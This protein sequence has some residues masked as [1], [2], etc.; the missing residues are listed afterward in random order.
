[1]LTCSKKECNENAT[2]IVKLLLFTDV[3]AEP[4][5]VFATICAC[6]EEHQLPDGEIHKFFRD[7]WETLATGFEQRGFPRPNIDKTQF[8]WVPL[9]DYEEFKRMCENADPK[10]RVV[11]WKN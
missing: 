8:A 1:M 9:E 10:S 4:A 5:H 11:A 7:T 6:C 2:Q 3:H